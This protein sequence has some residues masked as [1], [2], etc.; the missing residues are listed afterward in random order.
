VTPWLVIGYGNTLRGDDGAGP[1]VARVV[2]EWGLP[3]VRALAVHQLTPELAPEV[4]SAARVVFVDASIDP[5]NGAI[6]LRLLGPK[7]AVGSLGHISDPQTLLKLAHEV[8]GGCPDAWLVTIPANCVEFGE[9]FST[10]AQRGINDALT[11]IE[12]W[13]QEP[14]DEPARGGGSGAEAPS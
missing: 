3:G 14:L 13:L 11:R 6:E 1:E 2:A 4:A 8:Y 10:A 5:P 12:R 7:A 9:G